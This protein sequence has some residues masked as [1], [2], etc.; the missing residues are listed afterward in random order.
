[1]MSSF[2]AFIIIY[3]LMEKPVSNS[4]DFDQTLHYGFWVSD[5][6]LHCLPMA[7]PFCWSPGINGL[8]FMVQSNYVI[9]A[10]D[11]KG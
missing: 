6:G 2:V 11:K 5:L 8:I 1:M 4:V 7:G 10:P 9:S 3:F